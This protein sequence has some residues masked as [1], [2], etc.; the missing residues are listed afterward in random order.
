MRKKGYRRLL[1]SYIPILLFVVSVLFLVFFGSIYEL[2]RKQAVKANNLF[3]QHA[4]QNLNY[5]L[6]TI[7]Q[8]M[9]KEILTN[10]EFNYFFDPVH[11]DDFYLSYQ[12]T[13]K[14]K[15]LIGTVPLVHSIYLY[16][17]FDQKVLSSNI[18]VPVDLYGDNEFIRNLNSGGG[19]SYQWTDPRL[20][21]E[22]ENES[23][24]NV[25]SLVKR[26]PLLSG[27]QGLIVVNV[28]TDTL[29]KLFKEMSQSEISYLYL[30]D[31]R[32]QWIRADLAQSAQVGGKP[33]KELRESSVLVSELS[34]WRIY[35]GIKDNG[36][37]SLLRTVSYSWILLGLIGIII[38]LV[39][40][41]QASR[42]HYKPLEAMLRRVQQ[43]PLKSDW[44][45]KEDE[46]RYI[47]TAIDRL[48]EHSVTLEK[49]AKES[50]IYRKKVLFTEIMEGLR[51]LSGKEWQEEAAALGWPSTQGQ[52]SVALVEI[53]KFKNF[54]EKYSAKD[55]YLLKFVLQDVLKEMAQEQG[56][57]VWA[58][59]LSN[60]ELGVV[61]SLGDNGEETVISW[62]ETI[63]QWLESNLQFTVTIA[64]GG[65]I[66]D[67]SDLS[68]S[69]DEASQ[70]LRYKTTLGMNRVIVYEDLQL[71]M[72]N[73]VYEQQQVIR[74]LAEQYRLRDDSWQDHLKQLVKHLSGE[75]F[76]RTELVD[77]IHFLLYQFG[78]EMQDL[79]PEYKAIWQQE[80]QSEITALLERFETAN[81]LLS[82]LDE[83]L[84]RVYEKM[85]IARTQ[86]NVFTIVQ[87]IKSY[88]GQNYADPSLSLVHLSD[89]Y[90]IAPTQ[91]SRM[92]KEEVGEKLVDY[93]TKIRM[94][95][96]KR[97]LIDTNRPVQ[98]VALDVGYVHPFSFIRAFK[99]HVGK[100][101]GDFRKV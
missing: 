40:L 60:T 35:A 78:R 56:L 13:E 33:W 7:D 73:G 59:W 2:S 37:F 61:V 91:L 22:F 27:S 93:L 68:I 77:M 32:E 44:N 1:F 71:R 47:G 36:L 79:S 69:R 42:N 100:T 88:L 10:K 23:S 82:E 51:L 80:A 98:D 34:G 50:S 97:L 95:Q 4:L 85:E 53:D 26:V 12:V 87:E 39:W 3:A 41:F 17:T 101:P 43:F 6:S 24:R 70:A 20:F 81:E 89:Q 67:I 18:F 29:D 96:A 74:H 76:E 84:V 11:K 92:F 31:S 5:S 28:S 9:I 16:R 62:L 65:M 25:V 99:K 86:K 48:L 55:Q 30:A 72:D 14:L 83:I 63:R 15:E 75:L 54:Q 64:L 94:E 58:E 45:D 66:H 46:F 21:N 90:G 49:Q 38:G 52:L 19:S 8:L 57:P